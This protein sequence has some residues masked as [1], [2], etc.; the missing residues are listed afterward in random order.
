MLR[1]TVVRLRALLQ[2]SATDRELDEE[3]R[4]HVERAIQR[5]LARGMPESQARYA[6]HREFGNVTTITENARDAWRW[7]WLEQLQQDVRYA[8]RSMRRRPGFTAVAVTSIA[9]GSGA[10]IALFA[11]V[12]STLLR[13]LLVHDPARLVASHGGSY[14]LYR[15]LR[16]LHQVFSDVAAVSLLDRSNVTTDGAGGSVDRGLVRVELVSGNYFSLLGVKPAVGRTLAPDDDRAPGAHPVAVISDGY[17]RRRFGGTPDILGRTL[18]LNGTTYTVVGVIAR[19]FTGETMGRPVDVWLPIMMQSQVMLE[20]PGLLERNNGW[21]RIIARLKP[22]VTVTQAQAAVQPTYR[23][24][25]IAFAGSGVTPLFIENLRTNPFLLVPIEHGYSRSR[26]TLERSMAILLAIVGAVLVIACANVAA[27]Q[28]ARAEARGREMAIRLA[29]GAARA[30]LLRQL[31]TESVVM[32]TIG[33]TLGVALAIAATTLLSTTISVGPVQMDARAPSSWV[34]LDLHPHARTYIVAAGISLATGILFGLAPAFRGSRVRLAP[35]LMGRGTASSSGP[36]SA[37]LGRLFVVAQ[38]ALTLVLVVVTS[39]FIRTLLKLQAQPLGIDRTHLLLVWTAPGQAG[40]SGERLPDFIRAVLDSVARVPGVISATG[41]NHGILEGE[42]GG[43]ASELLDIPG[44]PPKPGLTVMRAGVTPGFFETSGMSLLDGRDLTERDVIGAPRAAVINETMSHFFF[45]DTSP[46]G[47]RLGSG[48]AAVEII[49]VVKD[50]KHGTPRDRRGVWYV[51][52]RQY[53]GL[54]RNLCIVVRTSGDPRAIVGPVR[55]VLH[56]IEPNLPILRAD[57]IDEQLGDTLAHERA[58]AMLSLGF[59]SFAVLLA[60][61]GLYGVVANAVTRRTNEIGIRMALGARHSSVVMMVF[62]DTARI[63]IAGLAIGAPM[64]VV[65]RSM[66]A[67]RLYDVAASDPATIGV[68]MLTLAGVT[69]IAGVLPA[70]RAARIDP[71]TAL[72]CD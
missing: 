16:E 3:L 33:G 23:D 9:L 6:A 14:P 55:Q 13:P 59:G 51:S 43:G 42:D 37:Y 70:Y 7:Q 20:M 2:R 40:R 12:D 10:A 50:T 46:I 22:G 61:I 8:L 72:R 17:W 63:V 68:A 24:N 31:L 58:I 29:I 34:S 54:M 21:L 41:T 71:N 5:N 67:N 25:E 11:I 69:A 32:A 19:G 48:D 15:R 44:Q 39:L 45:G 4:I 27:L 1:R 35:S 18:G 36:A 57:T 66:I 65:A 64:T 26:D 47:R 28:L 30:R 49:G 53:P 52:Y 62:S 38:V 60:C 56:A